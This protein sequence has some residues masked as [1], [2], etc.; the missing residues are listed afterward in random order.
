MEGRLI[1]QPV[2]STSINLDMQ[3]VVIL[4]IIF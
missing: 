3:D 1:K 2:D 4:S